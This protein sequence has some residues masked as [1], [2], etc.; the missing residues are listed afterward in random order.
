VVLSRLN[1][2]KG[3]KRTNQIVGFEA[4]WHLIGLYTFPGQGFIWLETTVVS[5]VLSVL[6]RLMN[7][8]FRSSPIFFSANSIA[9]KACLQAISAL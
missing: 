8:S 9:I 6:A 7:I 5:T 2:V 3:L 4:G 1:V